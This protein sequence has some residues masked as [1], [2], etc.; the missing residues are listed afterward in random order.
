VKQEDLHN[1]FVSEIKQHERIIYKICHLYADTEADRE[2]LYQEI[3]IQSWK[4]YPKFRG[5]SKFST[6]LY[7]I[8]INT[9]LAGISKLK[10]SVTAP[11]ADGTLPEIAEDNNDQRDVEQLDLLYT[12]IKTLNDIEK[13]IVM[14]YLDGNTYEEMENVMGIAAGT[15]RVKMARVKEKLRTITKNKYYGT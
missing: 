9:A 7:R 12:A 15:L 10:R 14:L 13:A 5:D 1:A 8:A 2:D 4:G 3:V 11:T 6:W